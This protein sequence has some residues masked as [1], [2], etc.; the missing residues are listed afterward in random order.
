MRRTA[1]DVMNRTILTVREDMTTNELAI[2]LTEKGI[3]GAPV[4]N[5]D[6]EVVGVVSLKDL[7]EIE[8]PDV[9]SKYYGWDEGSHKIKS[10]EV[11]QEK[12]GK[13]VRDVM[14][15]TIF[16]V[17]P[18]TRLSEIADT[19]VKGRIHRLLVADKRNRLLGI[20]TT[21]DVLKVV[22]EQ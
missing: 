14:T 3:S 20:V 21:L 19:M 7:V 5:K 18:D 12:A 1:Q 16:S 4:L 10:L 15:T 9:H 17:E 11:H 13:R 8:S 6:D 2:F 22:A